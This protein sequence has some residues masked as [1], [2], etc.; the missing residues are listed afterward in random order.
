MPKLVA[1]L[2]KG[3]SQNPDAKEISL[4]M[5][6]MDVLKEVLEH[7]ADHIPSEHKS[8]ADALIRLL[9][10]PAE[11]VRKVTHPSDLPLLL[12]LLGSP[13]RSNCGCSVPV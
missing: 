2:V 9:E 1:S 12:L 3:L 13:L 4:E 5:T 7:Y 10:H 11:P 6:C 8:I